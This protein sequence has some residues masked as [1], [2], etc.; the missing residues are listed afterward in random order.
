M[1]QKIS[2][3]FS[4]ISK[5][6]ARAHNPSLHGI[7]IMR[8]RKWEKW[9]KSDVHRLDCDTCTAS[10]V[11]Q[12]NRSFEKDWNNILGFRKI[13]NNKHHKDTDHTPKGGLNI[14]SSK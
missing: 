11:G 4:K 13:V 5:K 12:T 7:Y 10:Y 6:I 8:K 2:N 9:R 3:I 1:S 14:F